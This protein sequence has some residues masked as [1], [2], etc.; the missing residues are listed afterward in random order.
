ME[1]NLT[2]GED[3]KYHGYKTT[4]DL[5]WSQNVSQSFGKKP[6]LFWDRTNPHLT[7]TLQL[8]EITNTKLINPYKSMITQRDQPL[9]GPF[10]DNPR[11]AGIYFWASP[12]DLYIVSILSHSLRGTMGYESPVVE[13]ET[14]GYE[15]LAQRNSLLVRLFHWDRQAVR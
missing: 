14:F 6:S 13:E 5:V 4:D 3:G 11:I 12:K 2:W 15:N 7:H 1:K 8:V 10:L 9:P